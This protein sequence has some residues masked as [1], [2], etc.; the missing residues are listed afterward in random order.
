MQNAW[1]FVD[2]EV[3][4]E[5]LKEAKGIG[6]PA[7]HAPK[8]ADGESAGKHHARCAMRLL[9]ASREGQTHGGTEWRLDIISAVS[10]KNAI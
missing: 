5:R 1:R 4:R 8:K 6:T 7:K 10:G 2:D 9:M 3:L